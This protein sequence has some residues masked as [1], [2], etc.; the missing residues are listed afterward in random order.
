MRI[1]LR[2]IQKRD[3][4]EAIRFA[5]KGMNFD[6]YLSSRLLLNLYG[7]YFWYME[8]GRSSQVIAAY[9]G[10]KFVGVLLADM[11]GEAKYAHSFWRSIY[12][13]CF[14]LLQK[15]FCPDGVGPYDAA[16]AEMYREFSDKYRADGEICFLAADPDAKIKGV[17]T[18]LLDEL[19]R[20]ESGKRIFLY[21]D[22]NCTYQFYEHRGFV[23]IVE[24]DVSLE[25]ANVGDVPLSCYLYSKVCGNGGDT[26]V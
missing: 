12:V 13:K 14:D 8:L 21:T 9:Y 3:Y 5:I 16:N 6:R 1:E 2:P 23:R 17:G 7:R 20:R 24:K 26:N 19:E 4:Q 11:W 25:F 10:E 22:S 15:T 18:L